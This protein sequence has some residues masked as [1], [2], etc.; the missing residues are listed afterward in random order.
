LDETPHIAAFC[1]VII[2]RMTDLYPNVGKPQA[3]AQAP[4]PVVPPAQP[5][6]PP[7]AQPIPPAAP[8][9]PT[10]APQPITPPAPA[11]PSTTPLGQ[12]SA[13][14]E[15]PVGDVLGG[16]TPR[17][18]TFADDVKRALS[19]DHMSISKIAM[20]EQKRR[21]RLMQTNEVS[22]RNPRNLA[23]LFVSL[24]L[25]LGGGGTIWYFMTQVGEE[26]VPTIT[27]DKRIHVTYDSRIDLSFDNTTRSTISE[28]I[29]RISTQPL[30][31][32]T[33]TAIVYRKEFDLVDPRLFLLT[34]QSRAPESLVRSL[35]SQFML[36]IYSSKVNAPFLLI[37]SSSY[38]T[39]YSGML[40][41][42]KDLAVDMDGIIYRKVQALPDGTGTLPSN[43]GQYVDRVIA[44][45]DARA[46][47]DVTGRMLFYYAFVTNDLI[48]IAQND[49]ALS[50][51]IS[52][53]QQQNFK[54]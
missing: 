48:I 2:A 8:V 3:D 52:R 9:T 4:Q 25:L 39:A 21:D 6:T 30:T 11:A 18:H 31:N 1:S 13:L 20:E 10:P 29:A 46:Y 12:D 44:N 28:D 33:I 36:G 53:V 16:E 15:V 19:Q 23:L 14:R 45:R 49:A 40:A 51:V 7:P 43:S 22:A 32:D 34:L 5:V 42:E 24:I 41:W 38:E 50:E 37:K 27:D 35:D 17:I 54:R 26:K 47:V